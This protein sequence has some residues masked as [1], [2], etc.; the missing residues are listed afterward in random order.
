[1]I[2]K[3]TRTRRLLWLQPRSRQNERKNNETLTLIYISNVFCLHSS[4]QYT[5][6]SFVSTFQWRTM[7]IN[8]EIINFSPLH[9]VLL[10]LVLEPGTICPRIR[11]SRKLPPHDRPFVVPILEIRNCEQ[12]NWR[13]K[14]QLTFFINSINNPK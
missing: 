5:R 8:F 2:Q 11:R 12:T 9:S 14:N 6:T 3:L 13:K 7:Y 1:M 10:N 4:I